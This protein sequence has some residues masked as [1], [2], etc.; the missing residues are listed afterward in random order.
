MVVTAAPRPP[1]TTAVLL[2]AVRSGDVSDSANKTPAAT[3]GAGRIAM[4][5]QRMPTRHLRSRENRSRYPVAAIDETGQQQARDARARE[6]DHDRGQERPLG[7]PVG[8][9]QRSRPDDE[10]EAAPRERE[11]QEVGTRVADASG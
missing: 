5:Y 2:S 3:I 10:H 6:H 9:D 11:R 7:L 4:A 8:V 1:S